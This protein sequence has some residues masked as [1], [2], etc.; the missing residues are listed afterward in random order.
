MLLTKRG[1]CVA[2][3]VI[4]ALF[5]ALVVPTTPAVADTNEAITGFQTTASMITS[6]EE[7]TCAVE[8]DGDVFCWGDN[9]YGQ[10]GNATNNDTFDPNPTPALVTLPSAAAAITTG[11]YHTCAV[12]TDGTV[13]C[14][15]YN[16][17]GQLG[18][19][20][21]NNNTIANP[22]PALVTLPSAAAAITG[23]LNHTCAVL[24]D[25]TV[26]CWGWNWYGQL[27]NATNNGNSDP[28][29]APAL[30]TLPSAVTDVTADGA[31]TCAVLA[32]GDVYCWGLNYHG[33]LG[34][35]T[36][37]GNTNPNPTPALVTLP[38]AAAAITTGNY[39]TCAVLTNSTVY[40]WGYNRVGQLGNATNS[41]TE[42]ANPAPALV[43]LASA[44]AAITGGGSHTCAV[45]TDGDVYCWGKNRYGQLGNDTNS[46]TNNANPAPLAAA[47]TGIMPHVPSGSTDTY[48][49][50]NL[51]ELEPGPNEIR[52]HGWSFDPDLPTKDL[53]VH[54]YAF[55]DGVGDPVALD[56]PV[57][58]AADFRPDINRA[59][60]IGGDH[61]FNRTLAIRNGNHRVC[62]YS[63][64]V[65]GAGA[66]DDLNKLIGCRYVTVTDEALPR[67][68]FDQVT[69][70]G[71]SMNVSG[72]AYDLDRENDSLDI[73]VY[74]DG[75]Y[76]KTVSAN[77]SRTDVNKIVQISG[78]HGFNSTFTVPAGGH[79]V[80]LYAIGV[81]PSGAADGENVL[82]TVI[83]QPNCRTT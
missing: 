17:Y 6:G 59:F 20:T 83:D 4:A 8:N 66:L 12:L 31:H 62:V 48:A 65:D 52:I 37:N 58:R 16:R 76:F 15:G 24:T 51:E 40:C 30:V 74:L 10:L 7:H 43:T 3:V 68:A 71:T 29:P 77:T 26:Y 38:S 23:G 75:A 78:D 61:G 41:G 19:A 57:V 81:N 70:T 63:L 44:V 53:V 5:V 73:Q 56:T 33:Q 1:L 49:T 28:N 18:N 36:N 55:F 79:Q 14:W 80:C 35:A 21:N 64:S 34:N 82:L 72:W 11:N 2:V 27:G 67:G 22:T 50:A 13:Y 45:V 32:D 39:H 25:G 69:Q 60:G 46:D 54:V 9:Y 42:N 47:I